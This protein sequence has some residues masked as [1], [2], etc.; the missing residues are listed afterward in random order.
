MMA[1]RPMRLQL[2][3]HGP[4]R[5]PIACAA[6]A[7]QVRHISKK[8][9]RLQTFPVLWPMKGVSEPPQLLPHEISV[10]NRLFK[11]E[12]KLI[13]STADPSDLPEWDIPEVAFAGRSNVGKSSIINALVGQPGLVRTSKTPGRTQQLH[14]FSVGGKVGS[15]PDMSLVDMPGY[16]FANVP[17]AVVHQFHDLV[18]GYVERRRG[19]NLRCTYLLIDAR[20]GIGKVDEEFMDYL[21]D[22]GTIYQVVLTKADSVS[23]TE[24]TEQ[25]R[26]GHRIA[27]RTSRLNMNPVIHVTS[28]KENFGVKELQRQIVS[29]C[30]LVSN[31]GA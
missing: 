27:S 3:L 7:Q 28:T 17:K 16:G 18:G 31:R 23:P 26:Q 21:R 5:G 1:L 11:A 25:I 14:F 13:T 15:L 29:M 19:A 24:L 10:V 4:R 2:K 8:K 6:H 9:A 12:S 30:G 22:L 20:R